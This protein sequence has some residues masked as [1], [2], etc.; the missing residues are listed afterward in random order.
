MRS[1]KK[2]GFLGFII[3]IRSLQILLTSLVTCTPPRIRWDV[4]YIVFK[5]LY[6]CISFHI[7]FKATYRIQI[8]KY[9]LYDGQAPLPPLKKMHLLITFFVLSVILVSRY[10]KSVV[11]I[12]LT[13]VIFRFL[14]TYKFS[15]DH[16]ELF[17][18]CVRSRCGFNDNPTVT[19]FIAA[20]KRLLLHHEIQ[21]GETGNCIA[22][23]RTSLLPVRS[24]FII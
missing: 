2:V 1:R 14:L 24:L 3:S 18:G 15:Q 9:M 20:Y 8:Y 23:D 5:F 11:Y 4:I 10:F 22:L 21:A 16:L 7:I 13:F 6:V 17:F 19:Q 12:L